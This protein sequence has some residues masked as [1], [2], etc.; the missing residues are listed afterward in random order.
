[1]ITFIHVMNL[2]SLN[3]PD[4][5]LS[6]VKLLSGTNRLRLACEPCQRTGIVPVHRPCLRV[7]NLFFLNDG[8]KPLSPMLSDWLNPYSDGVQFDYYENFAELLASC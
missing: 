1:M 3:Q 7:K 2:L 4:T 6:A 8:D 5:I